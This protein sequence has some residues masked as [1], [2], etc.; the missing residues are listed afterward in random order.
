MTLRIR[1]WESVLWLIANLITAACANSA[2]AQVDQYA[3]PKQFTMS[4]KGVN[5]QTGHFNYSAT[6]LVYGDL[7]FTRVWG[8]QEAY[9]RD[10]AIGRITFFNQLRYGWNHTLNQGVSPNAHGS[11]TRF[12]VFVDGTKFEFGRLSTGNFIPIGRSSAG[13]WLRLE[14]GKFKFTDKSGTAYTFFVHPAID[15]GPYSNL[16][17]LIEQVSRPDGTTHLYS[18]KSN[19]EVEEVRSS[20]GY[21]LHIDYSAAGNVAAVCGYNLANTYLTASQPCQVGAPKVTFGYDGANKNLTSIVAP[22][23]GVVQIAYYTF[24]GTAAASA[25][26]CIT[27]ADSTTCAITNVYA[28]SVSHPECVRAPGDMVLRQTTAEGITYSFC[29]DPPENQA[30][31]PYVRGR[32]RFSYASMDGPVWGQFAYDRGRLI[33]HESA[34]GLVR[35][36]YPNTVIVTPF[37][38]TAPITFEF[39]DT[40]PSVIEPA[41]G[42]RHYFIFDARGNVIFASRWPNGSP[43]PQLE[44]GGGPALSDDPDLRR[45]CIAPG[46]LVVPS[47]ASSVGQVFL[48][49]FQINSPYVVGCGSGPADAKRCDKPT[50]RIDPR[51]NRT[52]YEYSA[53]HGGLLSETAPAVDGVRPQTR[54]FYEQRYAYLRTAGGGYAQATSPVWLLVR[55]SICKAGS[56][57]G[58]GCAIAGDEVVTTY[59]YG[60]TSG[61]NNLQMRGMVEDAGGLALRTCYGYD[62]QGNRISETR[63]RAQLAGQCP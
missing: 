37:N 12:N 18:Y 21:A 53:E 26:T 39:M 34:D 31:V 44:G 20:R 56:A 13:T 48:P 52:D 50:T 16:R 10:R 41:P 4:P 63:P 27:L 51:G 2:F 29:I 7:K 30:D 46:T 35:Y 22:S 1:V 43:D 61:P 17:Q 11:D 54:Y 9:P 15:Q 42:E 40:V 45:C 6:D 3:F 5:I 59:E 57:S 28:A 47:G 33:E 62:A 8:D 38:S 36:R 23:G 32:P 25:P 19:G 58:T 60:P 49:S 55:K 14:A 24:L